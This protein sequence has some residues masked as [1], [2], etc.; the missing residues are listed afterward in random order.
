MDVSLA[1]KLGWT[2]VTDIKKAI[3]LTYHSYQKE[4][5]KIK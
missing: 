2:Y 3:S 5:N 4:K 1:K